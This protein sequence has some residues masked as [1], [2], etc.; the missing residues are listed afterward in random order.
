MTAIYVNLPARGIISVKGT[1]A[2][3]FLQRIIT[4][5]MGLVTD[6]RAIYAALL[7]PQG[8]YLYDFFV[9][10]WGNGYLLDANGHQVESL[11]KR[12]KMYRLRADVELADVSEDYRVLAI[13]DGTHRPLGGGVFNDPR[14]E[15][16]GQRVILPAAQELSW[17]KEGEFSTYESRRISLVIPNSTDDLIPE[18]STP[19]ELNFEELHAIDFGKG[20]YVGQEVTARMKHRATLRKRLLPVSFDGAAPAAGTAIMVGN[21]EI[22][23]MGSSAG[24][25]GLALLRLDRLEEGGQPTADGIVLNVQPY[26]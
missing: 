25:T 1:E 19:L 22:G 5:D 17:G 8:K 7:T 15:K 26:R 23:T 12:L 21:R 18:K 24:Q 11:L 2:A 3:D 9:L 6:E 14:S 10:A 13:Y 16:M 4:N 20:C